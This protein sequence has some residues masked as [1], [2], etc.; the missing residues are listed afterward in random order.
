[1]PVS[2]QDFAPDTIWGRV[3][4]STASRAATAVLQDLTGHVVA[5]VPVIDGQF[6]FTNL[7]PG[8][9]VVL[10]RDNQGKTLATSYT[11]SLAKDGVTQAF[12][13]GDQPVAAVPGD[14]PSLSRLLLIGAAAVGITV[15]IVV[16]TQDDDGAASPSR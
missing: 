4:Q 16:L 12:F 5:T 14:G 10:V 11:A 8:D 6:A 13:G 7:V 2:A 15:A 9:Y 3:P 1:M